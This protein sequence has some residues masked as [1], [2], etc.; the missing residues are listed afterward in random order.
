MRHAPIDAQLPRRDVIP[1]PPPAR[2]RSLL[3]LTAMVLAAIATPAT[4]HAQEAKTRP[5]ARYFPKDDLVVYLEFQGLNAHPDAWKQTAAYQ[6]L[7][8]TTLGEVV[9]EIGAQ[10][11]DKIL[12]TG[13][14]HRLSGKDCV[15]LIKHGANHGMAFGFHHRPTNSAEKAEEAIS[16]TYV[17]R[18]A[19]AKESRGLWSRFLGDSMSGNGAPSLEKR[20]GRTFVIIPPLKPSAT[21]P[22]EGG[23]AWWAEGDDLI[24]CGLYPSA[25]D[26]AVAAIDGKIP[27][28]VDHPIVQELSKKD[29]RFVPD[30]FLY[31]DSEH[32][33]KAG[34][35]T[36]LRTFLNNLNEK[37]GIRRL[38]F[39]IG[40]EGEAVMQE[41][42]FT[43]PK[44]RKPILALFE[45]P[46]FDPKA[47]MPLPQGV[48]SFVQLAIAPRVLLDAIEQLAPDQKIKDRVDEVSERVQ[49]TSKIDFH[50]DFLD[51]IG[52]RMILFLAQD[53]SAAAGSGPFQSNWLKGLSPTAGMSTS[54]FS[55]N[56]LTLLAEISEPRIFS[57]ALEAT[58]N[59]VNY[60]L[61]KETALAMDKQEESDQPADAQ[62]GAPGGSRAGGA[63]QKSKTKRRSTANLAPHFQPLANVNASVAIGSTAMTDKQGYIWRTPSDSPLKFGPASFHPVIKLDGKYLVISV[64]ADA[65]DEALKIARQKDWQPSED[66]RKASER[67]PSKVVLMGVNDPKEVMPELLATLPMTLQSIINSVIITRARANAQA[68]EGDPQQPAGGPQSGMPRRGGRGSGSMPMA[69]PGQ[70]GPGANSGGGSDAPAELNVEFKVDS[71]KLPKADAL[72]SRYFLGT[73]TVSVDD[74]EVR[75]ATRQAF[76]SVYDLLF[77]AGAV[78][79]I[80]PEIQK[81]RENARKAKEAQDSSS[82]GAPGGP[83]NSGMMPGGPGGPGMPGMPGGPGGPGRPGGPGGRRGG[84]GPGGN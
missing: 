56:K 7:T 52:P 12:S 62:P 68:S 19:A 64:S 47:L 4:L 77:S 6:M 74:Q 71:E 37:L 38:A 83:P 33:P 44:P 48:D 22:K 65:A 57:R 76:L 27:S 35:A 41:V 2:R 59:A 42:R 11:F 54:L 70:P 75:F 9:E 14:G 79:G 81:A 13:G 46:A 24:I 23:E 49:S 69:M 55:H 28:A 31:L 73:M 15:D 78:A 30:G 40:F 58:M 66:V 18:G 3:L 29:G 16:F 8:E 36:G 51:K 43:A 20:L 84:R 39:R 25:I 26:K 34:I 21:N 80:L 60:Q 50:K 61:R 53:K 63:S 67:I 5:L 10:L 1:S 32:A 17:F 72:R 82:G 45:Q